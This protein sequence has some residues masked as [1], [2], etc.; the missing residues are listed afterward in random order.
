MPQRCQAVQ[1]C[2]SLL[3][4][5]GDPTKQV[6]LRG[7]DDEL[8]AFAMSPAG[9][10]LATGQRG[11]NS[12][13]VVW[14][15]KQLAQKFRCGFIMQQA[16][17]TQQSHGVSKRSHS[18]HWAEP[19]QLYIT[20]SHSY[21]PKLRLQQQENQHQQPSASAAAD[22]PRRAVCCNTQVPRTRL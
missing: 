16:V 21:C 6:Q 14:D 1:M 9:N 4:L 13:V 8:T 17:V 22:L 3:P 2:C 7:H 15:T 18:R 19:Y 20:T 5:Q 12:D 10:M 11:Q